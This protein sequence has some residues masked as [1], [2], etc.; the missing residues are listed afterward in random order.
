[1]DNHFSKFSHHHCA[2]SSEI[3]FMVAIAV[4]ILGLQGSFSPHPLVKSELA[5]QLKGVVSLWWISLITHMMWGLVST[6]AHNYTLVDGCKF[7]KPQGPLSHQHLTVPR[8][9]KGTPT[10]QLNAAIA[11]GNIAPTGKAWYKQC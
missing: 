4:K 7:W 3:T 2:S 6:R 9:K 11:V 10:H 5:T 8:P 1:M